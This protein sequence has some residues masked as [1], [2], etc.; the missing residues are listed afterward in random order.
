MRELPRVDP[1]ASRGLVYRA[2][3]GIASSRFA[4]WLSR[5]PLW[6]ATVWRLDRVLLRVTRGRLGTGMLLPTALLQT[7][8]ARTGLARSTAVIYFHDGER[9][10]VVAS[11]AGVP[12]NPSWFYNAV[13]HPDVQLGGQQF[14]ATVVEDVAERERLWKL[15]DLVFPGFAVYRQRAANA[16]RE[17]PILQLAPAET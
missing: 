4:T 12:G 15:A 1:L 9:A 7:H 3:A 5:T 6:S 16:G 10:I 2:Q 8:G 13:A 17:I 11:Q 14:R